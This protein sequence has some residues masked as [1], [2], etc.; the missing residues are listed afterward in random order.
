MRYYKLLA[1]SLPNPFDRSSYSKTEEKDS[2]GRMKFIYIADN[3]DGTPILI[4]RAAYEEHSSSDISNTGFYCAMNI[5]YRLY[6]D[7]QKFLLVSYTYSLY[8]Y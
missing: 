4:K 2:L 1:D 5:P 6:I 7:F 3:T 8:P